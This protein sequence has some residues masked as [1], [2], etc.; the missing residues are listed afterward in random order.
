MIARN[1]RVNHRWLN[2][3]K[4]ETFEMSPSP[5]ANRSFLHGNGKA[6]LISDRVVYATLDS[7]ALK[8]TRLPLQLL[9]VDS[10]NVADKTEKSDKEKRLV[11]GKTSP[12]RPTYKVRARANINIIRSPLLREVGECRSYS[13][14]KFDNLTC[15]LKTL[16]TY[17]RVN[18]PTHN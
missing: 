6:A 7:L 9:P 11:N 14:R 1:L 4:K 17:E 16:E 18:C 2:R 12:K 15:I 3:K 10:D 8:R 13:Q 5:T